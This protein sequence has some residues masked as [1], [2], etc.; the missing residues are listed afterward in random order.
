MTRTITQRQRGVIIAVLCTICLIGGFALATAPV[1]AAGGTITV[2]Y[3]IAQQEH[4]SADFKI[5]KVGHFK[6]G[7]E[8]E[9]DNT[10]GSVVSKLPNVSESQFDQYGDQKT[11]KWSEALAEAAY[12][13]QEAIESP[14]STISIQPKTCTVGPDSSQ[15]T[16]E[17]NE[18]EYGLYL[19]LGHR[20]VVDESGVEVGYEPVPALVTIFKGRSQVTVQPKMTKDR[21]TQCQIRKI[22]GEEDAEEDPIEAALRPKSIQVRISYKDPED[23][24][25]QTA[26]SIDVINEDGSVTPTSLTNGLYT[27]N[28]DNNWSVLW[29]SVKIEREWMREEV[30][31][32]IDKSHYRTTLIKKIVTNGKTLQFTLKNEYDTD[33]LEIIKTMNTFIDHNVEGVQQHVATAIIF[34]IKG[35]IEKDGEDVK[36]FEQHESVLFDG[37][38]TQSV[39]RNIPVNLTKLVVEEV[40]TGNYGAQESKTITLYPED[41]KDGRYT[42]DF[43]NKWESKITPE[44]GIINQYSAPEG[45]PDFEHD[46]GGFEYIKQIIAPEAPK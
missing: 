28:G 34:N 46:D 21:V 35:Y 15:A 27:L 14:E 40:Y 32:P 39:S 38:G 43:T 4:F 9:W 25:Y 23:Q 18:D 29:K 13:L 20:T 31:E 8:L 1:H 5:Y 22:W 16:V 11:E 30:L 7:N 26:D 19:I 45:G 44:G 12:T 41:I 3:P 24:D 10:L 42:A 6:N 2:S 33:E 37:P 17:V 36:V